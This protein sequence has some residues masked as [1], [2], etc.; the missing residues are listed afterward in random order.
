MNDKS[1]VPVDQAG[2]VP[3]AQPAQSLSLFDK[4]A[5]PIKAIEQLGVFIAESSMFGKMNQNQGKV[6]AWHCLTKKK[7]P[8]EFKREYHIL[9]DGQITKRAD[10][11]AADF[12]RRGGKIKWL[13]DLNDDKIAKATFTTRDHD[14]YTWQF[15][16]ED[17]EG[18]TKN[19]E[20][21]LKKNWRD[22]APDMLR[23]RLISKS[24]RI[25]DPEVNAGVY[26]PEE[27]RD[28]AAM[29]LP[30]SP[31]GLFDRQPAAETT[32]ST[33]A[34]VI[35]T[36]LVATTVKEVAQ[37]EQQ[38][39]PLQ[40]SKPAQTQAAPAAKKELTQKEKFDAVFARF[41]D[42]NSAS[43]DAFFVAKAWIKPGQS[44]MD[45]TGEFVDRAHKSIDQ[46][47]VFYKAWEKKRESD[48]LAAEKK[49]K[50]GGAK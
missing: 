20:G 24:I 21:Y 43:V 6:L 41:K 5:D 25:L 33:T 12:I 27:L 34:E 28:S 7:D 50:E 29:P 4:I 46:L 38:A 39:L 45:L 35:D 10:A 15:A 13:S 37:P 49:A 44:L 8:F 3:Q 9:E 32:T 16:I 42:F 40:P 14:E 22:S 30:P 18:Y 36:K 47:V 17:A 2:A 19:R 31:T 26:T 11:M 1:I 48:R 23:A